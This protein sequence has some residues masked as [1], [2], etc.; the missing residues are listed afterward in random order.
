[1]LR[2]WSQILGSFKAMFLKKFLLLKHCFKRIFTVLYTWLIIWMQQITFICYLYLCA[3]GVCYYF[4]VCSIKFKFFETFSLKLAYFAAQNWLGWNFPI[5][6]NYQ[7][8]LENSNMLTYI[9]FLVFFFII[10]IFSLIYLP[11]FTDCIIV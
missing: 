8:C 2:L 3:V 1:M 5:I 4:H 11:S 10:T 6:F 9:I 7:R